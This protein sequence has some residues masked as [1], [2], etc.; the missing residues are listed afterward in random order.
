MGA[1]TPMVFK[2]GFLTTPF[3]EFRGC[4]R[5]HK[6]KG[7]LSRSINRG[8]PGTHTFEEGLFRSVHRG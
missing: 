8:C 1:L 3:T 5:T 4:P 6:F 7:G 2:E